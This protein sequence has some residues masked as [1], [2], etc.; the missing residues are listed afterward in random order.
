MYGKIQ[1]YVTQITIILATKPTLLV[2][3]IRGVWDSSNQITQHLSFSFISNTFLRTVRPLGAG[4]LG[5]S[6]W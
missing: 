1:N 4:E 2:I 6:L 5:L 3:H